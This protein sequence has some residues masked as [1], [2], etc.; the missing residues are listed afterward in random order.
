[1]II[2]INATVCAAED[3]GEDRRHEIAGSDQ[4]R[5]V[6]AGQERASGQ[7]KQELKECG[8]KRWSFR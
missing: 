7:E 5:N 8:I 3:H 6:Q 1:M 2:W 4:R